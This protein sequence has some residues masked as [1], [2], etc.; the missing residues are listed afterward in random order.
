MTRLMTVIK[1]PFLSSC[2]FGYLN[3]SQEVLDEVP[4]FVHDPVGFQLPDQFVI[5]CQQ[6]SHIERV[7]L[8]PGRKRADQSRNGPQ[9]KWQVYSW[10][11]SQR[12][13]V[14]ISWTVLVHSGGVFERRI[15]PSNNGIQHN[16]GHVILRFKAR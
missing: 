1:V 11:R 16:Y 3:L 9:C 14:P 15:T 7:M 12:L 8:N 6:N 13:A 4:N 5:C 10:S 2:M